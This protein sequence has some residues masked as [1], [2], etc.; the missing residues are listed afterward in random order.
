MI[1][2][3][4]NVQ[5]LGGVKKKQWVKSLCNSNQVNFLS[6]QETKMV[7]FDVFVGKH[8]I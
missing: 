2:L 7:S 3:S 4:V 5:G 8:V 1:Y 6:I